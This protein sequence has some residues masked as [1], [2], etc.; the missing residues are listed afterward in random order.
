IDGAQHAEPRV[1][2]GQTQPRVEPIEGRQVDLEVLDEA[3]AQLD[4]RGVRAGMKLLVLLRDLDRDALRC[5]LV[6]G[7]V[8]LVAVLGETY[9][10]TACSRSNECR[11]GWWSL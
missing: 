1:G 5:R 2:A 4:R 9:R 8:A 7:G 6:E 10:I 3:H 11:A